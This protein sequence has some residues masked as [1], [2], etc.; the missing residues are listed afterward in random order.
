MHIIEQ[1]LLDIQSSNFAKSNF[2]CFY[3]FR[4]IKGNVDEGRIPSVSILAS[5]GIESSFIRHRNYFR[6]LMKLTSF[7]GAELLRIPSKL[8][9]VSSDPQLEE[10]VV[11]G[12]EI[13]IRI[14]EISSYQRLLDALHIC[15]AFQVLSVVYAVGEIFIFHCSTEFKGIFYHNRF[16]LHHLMLNV[17]VVIIFKVRSVLVRS[18]LVRTLLLINFLLVIRNYSVPL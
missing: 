9:N 7:L 14:Y 12:Y 15:R 16:L 3:I 13:P 8:R 11:K 10:R 1:P 18:I 4:A 17:K 5:S 6:C 2:V